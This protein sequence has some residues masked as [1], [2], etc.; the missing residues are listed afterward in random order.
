MCKICKKTYSRK[1]GTTTSLKG[2]LKSLYIT[3]YEE[4]IKLETEKKQPSIASPLQE[5]KKQMT[6]QDALM[7]NQKWASSNPKS[8]EIDNLISQMIALQDLP[9]NFVEGVGFRRLLQFI[10]PNYQLRGRQFFTSFICDEL[11]PKL[12]SKV[13]DLQKSFTKI[14]F[15]T[16]VWTEPSSNVSLLSLTAH[17]IT[18]DFKRIKLVLKCHPFDGRHTGDVIQE[19]FNKMLQE[20]QI[21]SNKIHCFI[22]DCGSNMIRA[23][24]LADIPDVSC[25]VHQLQLCVKTMLDSDEEMQK[26][27]YAF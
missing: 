4:C 17:G 19:K 1:G 20:W 25:T 15:T 14:S 16:D 9:F 24:R 18:E 7:K 6:L 8:V 23:M 13:V 22:R 12:A 5:A 26:N 3:E 21:T 27:V 2:H 10:V 11:Y